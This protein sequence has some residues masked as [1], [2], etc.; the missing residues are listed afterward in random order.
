MDERPHISLLPLW[1]E[2]FWAWIEPVLR[3]LFQISII[4]AS[5]SFLQ[6]QDP[7]LVRKLD[8]ETKVLTL[9]NAGLSPIHI[10]IY[11]FKFDINLSTDNAGHLSI[12]AKDPIGG[13]GSVGSI[14][15]TTSWLPW[16]EIKLDLAAN[17]LLKF[18][19]WDADGPNSFESVYCFATEATNLLSNQSNVETILTPQIMFSASHFG[20]ISRNSAFGGGYPK[21]LMATEA[22]IK[23]DCRA[24][25]DKVR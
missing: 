1:Y 15:E 14:L 11:A 2:R 5:L 22:Q 13:V 9:K 18:K 8:H 20:P 23:L 7:Q 12:N 24:L 25:Y 6:K 17:T 10:Q 4:L 3:A 21:T 16:S 19:R